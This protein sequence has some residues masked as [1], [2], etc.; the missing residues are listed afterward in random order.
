MTTKTLR[1]CKKA[2][3]FFGNKEQ[4]VWTQTKS[5]KLS[6][7]NF[8]VQFNSRIFQKIV[9]IYGQ[10]QSISMLRGSLSL[11]LE[12]V[13]LYLW[14]EIVYLS[15][16]VQ[17][18]YISMVRAQISNLLDIY[19]LEIVYFYGQRQYISMVRDS[20]YLWHFLHIPCPKVSN[21]IMQQKLFNVFSHFYI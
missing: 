10:R 11:W 4:Q 12:I 17:K 18:Q 2:R 9:Y 6:L 5:M 1:C 21:E 8:K 19:G 15:V 13:Y 7:T 3:K 16:Y 14:L 20:I